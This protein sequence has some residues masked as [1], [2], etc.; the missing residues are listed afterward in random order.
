MISQ[1]VNRGT[2][3][4]ASRRWLTDHLVVRLQPV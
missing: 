2:A 1:P 3:G 4:R